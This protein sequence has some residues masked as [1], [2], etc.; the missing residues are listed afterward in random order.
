MFINTNLGHNFVYVVVTFRIDFGNLIPD[1][2][3]ELAQ[4]S[5]IRRLRLYCP[6]EP[7]YPLLVI[8]WL[9]DPLER[10]HH[11][12]TQAKTA[13]IKCKFNTS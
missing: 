12:K 9:L 8:L 3:V 7:R 13:E 1:S 10:G 5:L 6:E 4:V 2:K 11:D